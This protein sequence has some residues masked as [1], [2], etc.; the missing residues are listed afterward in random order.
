MMR[1]NLPLLCALACAA[2][3]WAQAPELAPVV[4]KTVSRNID[5]PGELQPF[6]TVGLRAKL[7]GYVE[8]VLVDRGS[9][10]KEGQ[11]LVELSAP[12]LATRIAEAESRVHSAQADLLQAEAQLGA[13]QSLLARLKQAAATPGV[14]AGNEV[15]QAEKQVDAA[16]ALVTSR[17]QS[18][19]TARV[20]VQSQKDLQAYLKITS[21]FDGMV[22]DRM[23]HPGALAGSAGDP[24]LLVI[25]QIAHL[26]LVAAVPEEDLGGIVH[27][28]K[29]TFKV[30]AFPDRTYTGVIARL[31]HALDP[32]TRTMPVELDVANADSSLSPGMYPTLQWPVRR[33]HPALFVPKTAVVT[34]TERTFV[35]RDHDGKA[36]WVD[37]KKGAAEGDLIEVTGALHP[38]DKVVRR[39]TDELRPGA[40]LR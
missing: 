11:L 26:R 12:E 5:L 35:V 37:V 8:R 13:S 40:A 9:A 33:P 16:Q 4:S 23:V 25:Q 1:T 27:G 22:T 17:E 15:V 32:K 3:A 38:A 21:P 31:A 6:L 30:P 2:P 36:E 29:V 7:P 39:A 28:A 14:I 20:A 19:R 10:V 34:T 24:P 18:V